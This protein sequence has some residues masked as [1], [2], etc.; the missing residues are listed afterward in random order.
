MIS[1]MSRRYI[2]NKFQKKMFMEME[3]C[4]SIVEECSSIVNDVEIEPVMSRCIQ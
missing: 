3:K 4:S 1:E 2:E